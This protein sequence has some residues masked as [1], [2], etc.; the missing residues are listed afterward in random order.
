MTT[1]QAARLVDTLLEAPAEKWDPLLEEA[2]QTAPRLPKGGAPR[3]TPAEQLVA[4]AWTMKRVVVRL[5][6][7]LL[8]RSLESLGNAACTTVSRELLN[9][10]GA[11]TPFSKTL[12]ARLHMEES[13]HA[14]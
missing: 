14:P 7:R 10:R 11:L 2:S 8:T 13:S 12:D 1:R 9:L 4:D 6:A 3:R 5:H